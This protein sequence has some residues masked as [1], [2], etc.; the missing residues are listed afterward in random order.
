MAVLNPNDWVLP[1]GG[2]SERVRWD[3]LMHQ[4]HYLN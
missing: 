3:R 2:A 4:H 1:L